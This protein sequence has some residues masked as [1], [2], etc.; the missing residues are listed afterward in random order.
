MGG[1]CDDFP[2]VIDKAHLYQEVFLRGLIQFSKWYIA[3]VWNLSYFKQK[4]IFTT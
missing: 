1:K 2:V 3:Q 4:K